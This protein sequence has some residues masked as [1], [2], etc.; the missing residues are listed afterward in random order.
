MPGIWLV[1]LLVVGCSIFYII[2]ISFYFVR[3]PLLYQAQ[4][5]SGAPAS[6]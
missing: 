2:I 5:A 3:H 4:H 6:C 1:G